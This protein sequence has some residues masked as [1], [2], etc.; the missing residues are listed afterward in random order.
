MIHAL[1]GLRRPGRRTQFL[2][3]VAV[4][5]L[6]AFHYLTRADT[7]GVFSPNRG[8]TPLTAQPLA[9]LVHFGVSAL[10]LGVVPL[11]LAR[12]FTGLRLRDLGLGLGNWR[13]GLI[14]LAIGIPSAVLAGKI[15][16][17]TPVMRALYPLDPTL[18]GSGFVT[19]ALVSFLYFGAWEVLFRGVLLFGLRDD[20]GEGT[21]NVLQTALSVIAHFG[22]AVNETLAALPSG[23]VFGW[24][25]L[26][27]GS[28]WYIAIVHWVVGVSMDY[29]V[30]IG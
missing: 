11:V 2:V 17:A 23:L 1:Y 9:P 14:L 12:Q 27:V 25:D 15:G 19:Y 6:I 16:A 8:W 30:V 20:L 18:T 10:I 13:R 28:I 26:R 5:V 4:V 3:L 21:A 29:F 7:I 22:R 24:A